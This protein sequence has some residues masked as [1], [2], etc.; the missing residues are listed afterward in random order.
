MR[1]GAVG[2]TRRFPFACDRLYDSGDRPEQGTCEA[3]C[4]DLY[5]R[6]VGDSMIDAGVDEG[7]ILV[8]D[9]SL[10]PQEGTWQCVL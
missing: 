6:V 7:D 1:Y 10:E 4:S 9:K 3:S 2:D 8:I 5:G